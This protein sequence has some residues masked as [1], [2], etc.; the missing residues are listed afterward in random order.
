MLSHGA[1]CPRPRARPIDG[2]GVQAI[3]DHVERLL[4]HF[5]YATDIWFDHDRRD[6]APPSPGHQHCMEKGAES[7]AG[8]VL[9]GI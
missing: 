3:A 5:L 1:G 7:E 8:L 2:E 6:S 9:L 4:R